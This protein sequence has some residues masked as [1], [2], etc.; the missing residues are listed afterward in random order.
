MIFWRMLGSKKFWLLL[1]HSAWTKM[2]TRT[3]GLILD[4]FNRIVVTQKKWNSVMFTILTILTI[5]VYKSQ[6]PFNYIVS[7][8]PIKLKWIEAHSAQH[9]FLGFRGKFCKDMVTS[10]WRHNSNFW[11]NCIFKLTFPELFGHS[12]E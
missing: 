4:Y 3:I 5:V 12:R 7:V 10:T 6:S 1:T 2:M 8:F 11:V 9:L